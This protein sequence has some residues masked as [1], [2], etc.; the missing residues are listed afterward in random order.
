MRCV[1]CGSRCAA[2]PCDCGFDKQLRLHVAAA[3]ALPKRGQKV[4]KQ[5]LLPANDS[6][7]IQQTREWLGDRACTSTAWM[8]PADSQFLL[9]EPILL[10]QIK[11][12]LLAFDVKPAVLLLTRNP[13]FVA[14][15]NTKKA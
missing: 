7:F 8:F 14:L 13:F 11:A 4:R 12:S 10:Q 15:S 2:S 9:S 6:Y 3:G 5:D 1:L